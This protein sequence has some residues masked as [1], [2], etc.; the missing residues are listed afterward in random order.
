MGVGEGLDRWGQ[1]SCTR[2]CVLGP[3]FEPLLPACKGKA[4]FLMA[5]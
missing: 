1:A 3:G 2:F 4:S 5:E